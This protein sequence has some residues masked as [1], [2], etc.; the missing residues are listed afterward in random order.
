MNSIA[1]A[2]GATPAEW[3]HLADT[4]GL[5][6]DLL[7]V[8][9]NPN[10]ELSEHTRITELGKVP[11]RYHEGKVVG[12]PGWPKHQATDR[13]VAR[14]LQES[15]YGI[16]IQTRR[17]R[18]IDID[19]KDPQRAQE[20]EE[21]VVLTL[22]QMPTRRRSNSGKCLL[23]FEM[24]GEFRK[25]VIKTEHGIVE[26]L[27]NGQQFIAIGTHPSGVRYSW[28]GGLPAKPP[29]L[30]REE[31]EATWEGLA[32]VFG[33]PGGSSEER[34]GMVPPVPRLASDM[35]DPDVVWLHE[36]GWVKGFSPDGRVDI[37]CPW[38]D[39]H[40]PGTG[41]DTST[42]YFP[43]GV[44]GFQQGH[45]R[46]LHA[47]CAKRT[48]GDFVRET[49][50][51]ASDFEAVTQEEIDA[52]RAAAQL[53][54]E[55]IA[56]AKQARFTPQPWH[57]FTSGPAPTWIVHG[58]LPQ[59]ELTV[60]YGETGSGKTFKALDLVGAVA[61][62]VD[63]R[64]RKVK[65][66]RVVYIVAEGA[67]GFRKR[68][69]A[70]AQAHS[71]DPESMQL[72]VIAETPNLIAEDHKALAAAIGS[73]S[74]IVVDTLAQ[75]TPGA[76]EN[77]A[78]GMGKALAHCKALHRATGALVVLI[79]HSGKDAARG[80]RGWSG[81][82]AAC[83]AEIEIT[84]SGDVRAARITKMKDGDEA[85][86]FPFKLRPVLLGFDE[87]GGE[88]T[89]C[90][91]IEADDV[92]AKKLVLKGPAQLLVSAAYQEL[93]GTACRVPEAALIEQAVARLPE[94]AEGKADRR[95]DEVRRAISTLIERAIFCRE[96]DD[97]TAPHPT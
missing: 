18:A 27:A 57:T 97:I 20:V 84:R 58:V 92:P 21:M 10:A 44:G 11:S 32:A 23:M 66:G 39:G 76:D 95:R 51:G 91:V 77:S 56:K 33:L 55:A 62:G 2:V 48:D 5:R 79:H 49:G 67:G 83:D 30:R 85:A 93:A 94:P 8:V 72:D 12:F 74:V 46:C 36:N 34:A 68:V 52:A 25:R 50:L 26:F 7:P 28:D 16:C 65:Q 87:D 1:Q 53:K 63:W 41:G 78:E 35:A 37:R 80:A 40:T 3:H 86:V 14:W 29:T 89:S 13:E 59:A 6:T 60:I 96:G 71:V 47:S 38:E 73:A 15:D 61:R 42:S 19:I 82:K 90:T 17:M 4:L 43:A 75:T 31:F 64:G 69:Q 9:S 81:L 45:W 24:E 70:Y 22:G 88:I 54:D